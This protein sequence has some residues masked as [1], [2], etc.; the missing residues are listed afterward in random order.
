MKQLM[1]PGSYYV[2]CDLGRDDAVGLN[3]EDPV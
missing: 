1:R 3:F 2:V